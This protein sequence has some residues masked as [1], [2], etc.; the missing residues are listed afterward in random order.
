M[1]DEML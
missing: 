1:C